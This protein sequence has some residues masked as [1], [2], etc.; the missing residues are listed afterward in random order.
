[1]SNLFRSTRYRAAATI[2]LLLGGCTRSAHLTVATLKAPASAS[3]ESTELVTFYEKSQGGGGH[4]FGPTDYEMGAVELQVTAKG[5]TRALALDSSFEQAPFFWETSHAK[6]TLNGRFALAAAPDGSWIGVS[7][8]EG[9]TWRLVEPQSLLSCRHLVVSGPASTMWARAPM[10]QQVALEVLSSEVLGEPGPLGLSHPHRD[11]PDAWTAHLPPTELELASAWADSH[12]AEPAVQLMAARAVV[13]LQDSIIPEIAGPLVRI[14]TQGARSNP[15][16][17]AVLEAEFGRVRPGHFSAPAAAAEALF[18]VP[19]VDLQR[20]LSRWIEA[21]LQ[22][23][24]EQLKADMAPVANSDWALA[25]VVWDLARVAYRDGRATPEAEK[26]ALGLLAL[27]SVGLD[28]PEQTAERLKWSKVKDD[29]WAV[30]GTPTQAT[31]TYAVQV[32]AAAGTPSARAGLESLRW[33]RDEQPVIQEPVFKD[34]THDH[35]GADDVS[36]VSG[37]MLWAQHRLPAPH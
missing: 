31:A 34:Y 17:R 20:D 4:G 30:A 11:G 29:P 21:A 1:M 35:R 14:A 22:R 2:G 13:A 16:V 26:A 32:V 12:A 9:Q 7:R 15:A 25:R 6:E 5:Q 18:E 37:W 33:A 27:L 8:D 24:P 3:W 10:P 19:G 23:G 36:H 28:S